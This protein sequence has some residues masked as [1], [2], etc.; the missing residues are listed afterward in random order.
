MPKAM[1]AI[2][3][4]M[5]ERVAWNKLSVVIGVT[6]AAA[7][8]ALLLHLARDVEPEKIVSAIKDQSIGSVMIAAGFVAAGYVMLTLYDYFALQTIGRTSVPYRIAALASFTS[9]TIGHNLGATVLTGGVIRYRIYSAWSL[10]VVDVAKI[11]F[12]TGLTF[13]LGNACMLGVGMSYAPEAASAVNQLPP[14]INR[15]IGLGGLLFI[16]GYLLWLSPCPR[17]IGRANWRIVLPNV[18]LT[19]VQIGIGVVDLMLAAIAMYVLLPEGHDVDFMTLMVIFVTATLLGFL[20]HAPGSLGV[21]EAAMLIG[22]PQLQKEELLAALLIFRCLYF[23][24]PVTL[25]A[26]LLGLREVLIA[27]SPATDRRRCSEGVGQ[28]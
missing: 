23:L 21:I 13:W 7:A 22:L 17:V 18:R 5:R 3:Q 27:T 8:V 2:A 9:Y 14:W 4:A 6:I 24:L 1:S 26:L 25:A 16:A 10:G 20:S 28:G 19:F 12:V 11:A 15:L